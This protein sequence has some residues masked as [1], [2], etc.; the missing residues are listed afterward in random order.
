MGPPRIGRHMQHSSKRPA[1]DPGRIDVRF[2]ELD[3]IE[4]CLR[5]DPIDADVARRKIEAHELIVAEFDGHLI[6]YLRL[7]Y[8][9]S[10]L[11]FVGLIRI[12]PRFQRQGVSRAVLAFLESHLRKQGHGRLF[13]S[14][15]VNEP[16]AQAWHRAMGFEECGILSGVNEGGA[17]EIFFSKA[18]A[19]G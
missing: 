10:K 19:N 12:R 18:L 15:Q 13:S 4:A 11:P 8:L 9:W 7:E 2:A 6:G 17:G 16:S 1:L 14:S 5:S 3:D